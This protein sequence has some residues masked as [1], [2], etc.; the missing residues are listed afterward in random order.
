[1]SRVYKRGV[2]AV[3]EGLDDLDSGREVLDGSIVLPDVVLHVA[4]IVEGLGR[5]VRDRSVNPDRHFDNPLGRDIRLVE[6]LFFD[7]AHETRVFAQHVFVR[8]GVVADRYFGCFR[9]LVGNG[10]R[11]FQQ[12]RVLDRVGQL[13]GLRGA[14]CYQDQGNKSARSNVAHAR[15]SALR[16]C[17]PG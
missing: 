5:F 3:L 10:H 17:S 8:G 11:L 1:M 9:R 12:T 14:P 15:V 16:F 2:E 6:I 13:L 4:E 7:Q